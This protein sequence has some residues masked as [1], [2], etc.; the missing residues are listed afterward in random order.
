MAGEPMEWRIRPMTEE[1]KP[2]PDDEGESEQP[3][4]KKVEAPDEQ[5][6]TDEVPG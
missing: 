1:D 4:E 6:K 3:H 2:L 5:P